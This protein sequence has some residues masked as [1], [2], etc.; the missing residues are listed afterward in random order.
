MEVIDKQDFTLK[1]EFN[2]WR[3]KDMVFLYT[4]YLLKHFAFALWSNLHK[5]LINREHW[6][7]P[8]IAQIHLLQNIFDF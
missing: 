8:D 5:L 6:G 4:L 7:S 1:K 2:I 3:T